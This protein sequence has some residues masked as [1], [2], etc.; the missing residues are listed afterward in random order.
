MSYIDSKNSFT[1]LVSVVPSAF[2]SSQAAVI[3][4]SPIFQIARR[5]VP[6]AMKMRNMQQPQTR[7]GI[8][9]TVQM[10]HANAELQLMPNPHTSPQVR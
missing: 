5:E 9:E 2:V 3:A 1:L 4:S 7:K 6:T 8:L 10:L